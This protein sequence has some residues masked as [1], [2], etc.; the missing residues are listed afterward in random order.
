S[1]TLHVSEEQA[2]K[3]G[4]KIQEDYHGYSGPLHVSAPASINDIA[5][6][7]I[8]AV[9][10]LGIKANPDAVKLRYSS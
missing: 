1:E 8:E 10:T 9:K 6:P 5:F 2:I 7:W 4:L 3:Y